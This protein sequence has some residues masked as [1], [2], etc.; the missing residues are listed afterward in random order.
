MSFRKS[1]FRKFQKKNKSESIEE[2]IKNFILR[3]SRNGYYT[4]VSTLHQKFE[5]SEELVWQIVGEILDEGIIES[6]HD[7]KSGEM[8]LC[9][10]G[11]TYAILNLDRQRKRQKI[12]ELKN[13]NRI[14]K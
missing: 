8:K 4:K 2:K 1:N 6:T 7:E 13:K 12:K 10:V 5:I 14:K 3:N 11:K 9:E